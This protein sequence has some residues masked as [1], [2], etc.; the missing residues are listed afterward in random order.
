[1]DNIKKIELEARRQL[2]RSMLMNMEEQ[3]ARLTRKYEALEEHDEKLWK[4]LQETT[5]ECWELRAELE[6]L[7]RG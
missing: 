5:A 2:V 6:E 4:R 3:E 1:M 7:D